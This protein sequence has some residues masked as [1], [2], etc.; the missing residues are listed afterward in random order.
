[1]PAFDHVAI[2]VA[3]LDGCIAMLERTGAMRLLRRGTRT[4]TG[5]RIAMVV[6]ERGQKMELVERAEPGPAALLHIA[7]DV[8]DPADVERV[9]D[10]LVADGCESLRA[11]H[12]LA[13]AKATTALVRTPFGLEV[14]IVHYAEDSP[15]LTRGVPS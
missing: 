5:Q 6:D 4:G 2:E 11:P 7:V 3:D 15:D 12:P 13:A 8:H 14:Q 10:E 1:M 9:H